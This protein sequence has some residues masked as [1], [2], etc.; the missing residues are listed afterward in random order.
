M[1]V[2][3]NPLAVVATMLGGYLTANTYAN[4]TVLTDCTGDK[5]G[6]EQY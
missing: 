3:F 1:K 6:F 2:L 5:R 4:P